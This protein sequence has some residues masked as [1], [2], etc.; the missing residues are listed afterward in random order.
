M[1]ETALTLAQ[2]L[3]DR[4]CEH[5]VRGEHEALERSLAASLLYGHSNGTLDTKESFLRLLRSGTLTYIDVEPTL[6]AAAFLDS[7]TITASGILKTTA[8]IGELEKNILGR[9]L[10]V[11]KNA[12]EGWQLFGLQGSSMP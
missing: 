6:D 12:P 9:Y 4:R 7:A 8:R 1:S 2:T 11:W 10:C 3:E 5:L